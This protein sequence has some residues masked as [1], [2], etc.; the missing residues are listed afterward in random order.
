MKKIIASTGMLALGVAG[1][2]AYNGD[3]AKSWNLH[4][5]LRGFYDS[6]S[7]TSAEGAEVESFG[8]GV[9]AGAGYN[10]PLDQTFFG[11]DYTYGLKWY[12][13]RD[14]GETD[15]SHKVNLKLDHSFSER[16]KIEL[17]DS[18]TVTTEPTVLDQGGV[19]TAPR[20]TLSDAL[21]NRANLDF[22]AQFTPTLGIKTGYGNVFYD[23]DQDASDVPPLSP[24]RS[25]LLD[26]MEHYIPADFRYTVN[27]E[28]IALVG[29]QY[30]I[31]EYQDDSPYIVAP[32]G[33][34]AA[35]VNPNWRDNT[36]HYVYG[37]VEHNFTPQLNGA[38]KAGIQHTEY[39][40]ANP[41]GLDQDRTS[42]YVD[43]SMSYLY[44]P[45]S[46]VVLG[47][48]HQNSSTD[49]TVQ[50][51]E[52]DLV[53]I[54]LTHKVTARLNASL[55]YQWQRMEFNQGVSGGFDGQNEMFNIFGFNLSYMV[56]NYLT[57][58]AG[59]NFD[60]LDSDIAGRSYQRHIGYIGIRA[61][62]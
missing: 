41:L 55:N 4:G 59:Y 29:Y 17:K 45:G 44:N 24:S 46:Y 27:P 62:Y 58:E 50:D 3:S 21:R 39:D 60:D 35:L 61:T 12:E 54:S 20:R 8:F 9:E 23:Y 51:A 47:Y 36:S 32:P 5:A 38:L 56:N 43:A 33:L 16:F 30:G 37:G 19:V 15:Q 34:G 14:T 26:R 42:P 31:V 2:Q 57:A 22:T 40:N 52:S 1:L 11:L 10:L 7:T 53:F 18:L 49:V 6:N 48:R 25:Q 13:G 28:T